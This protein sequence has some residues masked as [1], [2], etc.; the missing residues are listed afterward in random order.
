M[1]V[2][3]TQSRGP[4]LVVALIMAG[5][6]ISVGLSSTRQAREMTGI[7]RYDTCEL[8]IGS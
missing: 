8:S 4:D 5:L 7:K 2:F 1:G 6:A 3:G